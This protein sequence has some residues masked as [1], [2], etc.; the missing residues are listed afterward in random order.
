MPKKVE[1][2]SC[3]RKHILLER[4]LDRE[5]IENCI[6][7]L[8]GQAKRELHWCHDDIDNA[9]AAGRRQAGVGVKS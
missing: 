7:A 8:Y 9:I 4:S 5:N 1:D 3:D 2:G 6:A